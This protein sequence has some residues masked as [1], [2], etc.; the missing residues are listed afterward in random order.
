MFDKDGSPVG[1]GDIQ[2]V[3]STTSSHYSVFRQRI[4]D[5]DLKYVRNYIQFKNRLEGMELMLNVLK[6]SAQ[7]KEV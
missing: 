1:I 2:M 6:R 7:M 5:H 3:K 4:P